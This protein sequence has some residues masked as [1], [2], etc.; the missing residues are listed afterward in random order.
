MPL[1]PGK[2]NVGRNIK[3]MEASGHPRDQSIA[4]ALNV[5][6]KH[7]ESGGLNQLHVPHLRPKKIR[8]PRAEK[9][10]KH[11]NAVSTPVQSIRLSLAELIICQCKFP[12]GRTFFLRMS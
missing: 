7:R 12:V 1:L 2:A 11:L 3:E 8:V 6:R 10:V 5:A 9:F 4:A